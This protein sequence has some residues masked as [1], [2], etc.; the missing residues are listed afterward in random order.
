MMIARLDVQLRNKDMGIEL[1]P[2][3]KQLLADKG[4]DRSLG[5]RP[6]RRTIQREIE[7]TLSEKILFGELSAGQIVVVDAV[8]EDPLNKESTKKKF[9]FRGEPK[10][11]A[12]AIDVDEA[13]TGIT[14]E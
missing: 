5:A 3:A 6:L 9:S 8:P 11:S 13:A 7:D 10:P 2:E 14:A 1:T 12:L 4:Y